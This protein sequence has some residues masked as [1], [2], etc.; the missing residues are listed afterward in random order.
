MPSKS[1]Q[2]ALIASIVF[3]TIVVSG[4]LVF[5]GLQMNNANT[6]ANTQAQMADLLQ[7]LKKTGVEVPQV[8]TASAETL[9]DDDAV[10]GNKNAKVTLIEFSD[11]QCPF[12]LRHFTQTFPLI[13]KNY[14]D[15]GKVK[16]VFRDFP[17]EFHENAIPAAKAAECARQQKGDALY[18]EMGDKIFN[19]QEKMYDQGAEYTS[20]LINIARGF[21]LEM[22]KFSSCMSDPQVE[23]EI[24]ADTQQGG[25]YGVNGTPG[26]VLN[27]GTK[28]R[29]ITGAQPYSAFSK[30]LDEMLK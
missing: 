11:Y 16:Y 1:S 29:L 5:L 28:S 25:G 6:A 26:F 24:E 22:K 30:A 13:K 18:F 20:T 21:G 12:C 27:D 19:S 4:S 17:L 9:I 7:Q 23:A 8:I 3:A 14:I 15:T 2:K 10:M